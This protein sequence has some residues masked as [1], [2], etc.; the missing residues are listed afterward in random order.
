[1]DNLLTTTL[2]IEQGDSIQLVGCVDQMTNFLK[3]YCPFFLIMRLC[4]TVKRA[5]CK[6]L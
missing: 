1:M 2:M 6:I 5:N 4:F 3:S